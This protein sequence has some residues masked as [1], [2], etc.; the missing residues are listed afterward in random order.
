MLTYYIFPFLFLVTTN[1][2]RKRTNKRKRNNMQTEPSLENTAHTPIFAAVDEDLFIDCKVES[3]AN[4]TLLW[5]RVKPSAKEDDFGEVLTAGKL[6]VS[7]DTRLNVLHGSED[8][9]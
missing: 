4:Y 3:I 1:T 7:P 8:G 9:E 2:Q 6:R 5:R